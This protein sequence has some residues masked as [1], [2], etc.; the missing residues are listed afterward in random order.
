MYFV[1]MLYLGSPKRGK[2]R[3][4]YTG[5]TKSLFKRLI[6]H[7]GADMIRGARTTRGQRLE[8][9]YFEKFTNQKQAMRR[10]HELKKKSPYNTKEWKLNVINKFK[11]Y[12]NNQSNLDE[13]NE[14]LNKFDS[15]MKSFK[16]D[17][18][19]ISDKIDAIAHDEEE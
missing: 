3:R 9:V 12:S 5:Y 2:K 18:K 15:L 10:E 16:K 8:L 17:F 4:I 19:E 11:L 7:L 13:I 6:Q 1:Y 14:Y